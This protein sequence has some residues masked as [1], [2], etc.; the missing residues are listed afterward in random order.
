MVSVIVMLNIVPPGL[1]PVTSVPHTI[2]HAAIFFLAGISF[3][4]A[5]LGREYFLSIGAF[6]FCAVMEFA[7]LYVPGRHARFSDFTI[8]A[9]AAIMGIFVGPFVLRK[10]RFLSRI[11]PNQQKLGD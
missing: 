8:D 11:S 3:G 4:I 9:I 7:Q 2:E 6:I 10:C 5:Y 1:R